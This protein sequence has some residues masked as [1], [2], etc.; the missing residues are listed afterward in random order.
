M[1]SKALWM[2]ECVQGFMVMRDEMTCGSVCLG[3]AWSLFYAEHLCVPG[4][5]F[6]H[7]RDP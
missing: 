7:F 1:T 5:N 4:L 2:L 6:L 3:Q